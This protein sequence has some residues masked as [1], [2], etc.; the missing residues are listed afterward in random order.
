M[1]KTGTSVLFSG[2][3]I[4]VGVQTI[5]ISAQLNLTGPLIPTPRKIKYFLEGTQ[6]RVPTKSTNQ[7]GLQWAPLNRITLGQEQFDPNNR[8]LPIDTIIRIFF[9]YLV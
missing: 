9:I 8:I 4:F 7:M 6:N 5:P 3:I 1:E 2:P